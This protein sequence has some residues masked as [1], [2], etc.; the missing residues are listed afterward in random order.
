MKEFV[1]EDISYTGLGLVHVKRGGHVD[2]MTRKSVVT[3]EEEIAVVEVNVPSGLDFRII[4]VI[5]L[6]AEP[7]VSI[8]VPAFIQRG[9]RLNGLYAGKEV[10]VARAVIGRT[11]RGIINVVN[12]KTEQGA[13]EGLKKAFRRLIPNVIGLHGNRREEGQE[14]ENRQGH[15]C[16]FHCRSPYEV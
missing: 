5:Q 1:L 11:E 9:G 3:V 15:C 2:V 6:V 13:G 4:R 16:C 14:Y 12:I 7:Q 10:L 8:P